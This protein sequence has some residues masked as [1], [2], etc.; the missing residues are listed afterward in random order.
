MG[1]FEF[2]CPLFAKVFHRG[3]QVQRIVRSDMVVEAL[4][5]GQRGGDVPDGHFSLVE[6]PEL[7]SGAVV[8]ALDDAVEMLDGTLT[9]EDDRLYLPDSGITVNVKVKFAPGDNRRRMSFKFAPS[10]LKFET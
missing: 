10:K 9:L 1:L 5:F 6:A 2:S 7:G 4:V 3:E 8:G